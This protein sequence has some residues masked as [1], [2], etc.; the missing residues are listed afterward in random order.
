MI[1]ELSRKIRE[2][3]VGSWAIGEGPW[4]SFQHRS[5]SPPYF[6]PG[7]TAARRREILSMKLTTTTAALALLAVS[8]P[9]AAQYGPTPPPLPRV[10]TNQPAQQQEQQPANQKAGGVKPSAKALKALIELQKAVD[11]NDTANIPAKIAAAQAV[12]STKEDR[13]LIGQM[14]L[15]AAVAAK[16]NA[17]MT[18]AI[19]AIAASGLQSPAQI[20]Q[21]YMALGSS[22]YN[23]KQYG[24]AAA[25]FQKGVA[26][27]PNNTDLLLNLGEAQFSEGQAAPAVATFQRV[28]KAKLAAGQKPEEA[29]YKRALSIAYQSKLPA[30]VEL[31]REW[32]A[33]YPNPDS[34][35]NAI[36]VFRNQSQQDVEGTLDLLRLMQATG[37]MT[38]PG[39]YA[40]FAE[41]AA[42]Q[43]NYNEA[44]A[45]IDAGIKAK[46]VDPSSAQFRD[47]IAALK[48]KKKATAADLEAAAKMSPSAVNLLRIGDRYFAMGD[49]SKAA[50]IYRQ[51]MTKPGSD[52]S[53]ANLHLGMA[54]A[55]AGD[56]AG[57]T[58][59]L[60]AVSGPRA[61]IAKYWLVYVQQHG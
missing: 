5:K 9:A 24:P 61:D 1:F 51:V 2:F 56:K 59:A 28:I 35:R 27:D 20:A 8:A 53:L 17:A 42:D 36:A 4:P 14:Q 25:A 55:R 46:I 29:L 18:A 7:S 44:Q 23:Q 10:E 31:G 34:W 3:K 11:A 57:A 16:D 52:K 49:Y 48:T 13:Y 40:L 50:D 19:D 22:L 33:A 26:L 43:L 45:V 60:N 12:A 32:V 30:A 58:A 39:D 6:D 21:L 37:A 38:T 54:L 47:T 41:S 15:K